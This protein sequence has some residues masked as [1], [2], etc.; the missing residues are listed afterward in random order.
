MHGSCWAAFSPRTE[1]ARSRSCSFAKACGCVPRSAAAHHALG[2][3]LRRFGETGD[4]R[5]EFEKAVAL[6]PGF[7]Q[8]HADLGLALLEAGEKV[9]AAEH[10]DRAIRLI[11]AKPDSAYPRYLRAKIYFEQGAVEKAA[12]ELKTA[13]SLRPDFAEAWSDLGQ[14]RKALLDD[15][16]A[17]AAFERSVEIDPENAVAQ[18]RLGAEYLRQGQAHQSVVHLKEA[19]RLDPRDQSTLYSLQLAL[20]Q[21]GKPEEAKAIKEKLAELLREIDRE[22]QARLRRCD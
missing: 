1:I 2:E 21:D 4:A 5:Q 12:A 16:G 9:K 20:R 7:G 15:A 8:A 13:V 11:G 3:S 22:S 17:M 18:Y 14:A 10:L 6:D 19:Y